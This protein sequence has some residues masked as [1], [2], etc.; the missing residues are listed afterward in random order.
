MRRKGKAFQNYLGETLANYMDESKASQ[1]IVFERKKQF[2]E[3]I[4]AAFRAS[5]PLVELN[6]SLLSQVHSASIEDR[7]IVVSPIPFAVGSDLYREIKGMLDSVWDDKNSDSWFNQNSLASYIDFFSIQKP[8]QPMVM[9]SIFGPI[10]EAWLKAQNDPLKRQAFFKWRRS[11][12]LW[13]SVPAAP[14]IK[15]AMIRGWYVARVLSQMK[16]EVDNRHSQKL[17][18]GRMKDSNTHPFRIH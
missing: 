14:E 10:G 11:R 7:Q 16:V 2:R 1:E 17:K 4:L 13:D 12:T 8:Y 3:Q 15:S 18:F 9:S 6:P 5:E